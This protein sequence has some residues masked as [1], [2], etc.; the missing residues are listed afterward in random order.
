MIRTAAVV[1]H[2]DPDNQIDPTFRILLQDLESLCDLVVLVSTS[3]LAPQHIPD[4]PKVLTICRPNIGYD[5]YSYRVGIIKVLERATPEHMFLLNSSFLITRNAK[6][7][8]TLSEMLLRLDRVEVI[9]ATASN[10]W[11]WH[12]Q[13]YLIAFR[14][15][16]LRSDWLQSWL[17]GISPRDSKIET[18]LAGELGLSS[19]IRSQT[20]S[21]D[22]MFQP[23]LTSKRRGMMTWAIKSLSLSNFLK[24]LKPSFWRALSQFNPTHFL[25]RELASD[26]GI[27]KTELVRS[28]PHRLPLKWLRTVSD[29]KEYAQIQ[30]YVQ[31]SQAHYRPSIG[32][33]TTLTKSEHPWPS[34]RLASSAAQRQAGVKIA[35]VVHLFY[36]ELADEIYRL[37]RNIVEPFD[38]IVTTPREG[39]TSGLLDMF[40]PLASSVTIAVS[41]NRGRD[42]GPFIAVHRAGLLERY[43]AVL[44][45]HS[46]RSTYSEQG[47]FWQQNLFRQLCGESLTVMRTLELLRRGD[48]GVVGPHDYYL[49]NPHYWG[50]NRATVWRLMQSLSPASPLTEADVPLGFFAGTMFWFTPRALSPLHDI[51]DSL[52]DFEPEGGQQDGTLAH[53][54]ER[55]FGLLARHRNLAVTSVHMDGR[56]MRA[57]STHAHTVPV[58]KTPPA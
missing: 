36:P 32:S 12:L 56:D 46:K 8:E 48:V 43:E 17:N 24:V 9:G 57:I 47:Q 51:P 27:V 42:V 20:V 22:V 13:S 37:L 53:A 40:S 35:V 29:D 23:S 50:A 45:L 28:N 44:K 52:L 33:M 19:A 1:A 6:F 39:A 18:I 4:S 25:A 41:E 54:L 49:T 21:V 34:I 14:G 15:S 10:Q 2:F 3:Q 31:R 5:F 38:L 11:Q 55:L 26:L 16:L 7:R 30:A 58:L